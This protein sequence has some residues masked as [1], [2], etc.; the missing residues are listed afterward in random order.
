[1]LNSSV[2]FEVLLNCEQ[3]D[4][5]S[6]KSITSC[7]HTHIYKNMTV[8]QINLSR[9]NR[10]LSNSVN[11]TELERERCYFSSMKGKQDLSLFTLSSP[12]QKKVNLIPS[13]KKKNEVLFIRRHLVPFRLEITY[14]SSVPFFF[15]LRPMGQG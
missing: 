5:C 10:F 15:G 8:G 11:C 2:N 4:P 1:M 14:W 7:Q 9:E 6:G 12:F 13:F 3:D